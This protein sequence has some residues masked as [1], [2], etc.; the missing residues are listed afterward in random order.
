M[1]FGEFTR[2]PS[3]YQIAGIRTPEL[4]ALT[5]F[6]RSINAA[7]FGRSATRIPRAPAAASGSATCCDRQ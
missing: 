5:G 1:P 3:Y 6:T 7:S 4:K 2:A